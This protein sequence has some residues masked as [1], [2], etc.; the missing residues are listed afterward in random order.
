MNFAG[1]VASFFVDRRHDDRQ[2]LLTVGGARVKDDAAVLLRREG[3]L[4][5]LVHEPPHEHVALL[6]LRCDRIAV[7]GELPDARLRRAGEHRRAVLRV[8]RLDRELAAEVE[9]DGVGPA[10]GLLEQRLE[11]LVVTGEFVVDL[12]VSGRCPRTEERAVSHRRQTAGHRD[13]AD[14]GARRKRILPDARNAGGQRHV[15]QRRA[16]VECI[17][18]D[19]LHAAGNGDARHPAILERVG[20]D[21]LHRVLA[22]LGRYRQRAGRRRLH[23]H[24]H[25]VADLHAAAD[26]DVG[27]GVAPDFRGGGRC[28]ARQRDRCARDKRLEDV[29]RR[30]AVN[31]TRGLFRTF[32]LDDS[33]CKFCD[34]ASIAQNP[35]PMERRI[36][37]IFGKMGKLVASGSWLVVSGGTSRSST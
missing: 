9:V 16:S 26:L 1:V 11:S 20:G 6:G 5:R 32:H 37:E 10:P 22:D 36:S 15:L 23:R 33:L 35:P 13:P 8:V 31:K 34:A 29:A 2:G 18:P 4:T 7:V 25:A 14:G 24:A 27:P 28:R 12:P 21:G 17:V 3:R 19:A 30:A